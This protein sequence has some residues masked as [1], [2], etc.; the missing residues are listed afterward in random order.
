MN[1]IFVGLYIQQICLCALFFLAEN[2]NSKPSA[3]Y[4]GALMVALIVLTVS[5]IQRPV[6]NYS[7]AP[8]LGNLPRYHPQFLRP[9][10][11]GP[12]PLSR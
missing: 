7:H 2:E 10:H 8:G 12:T 5:I 6:F 4:E 3:I 1:H 11:Q 9:S